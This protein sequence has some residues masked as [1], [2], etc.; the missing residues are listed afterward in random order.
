MITVINESK[1]LT[2]YISCE[3]KCQFYVRKCNCDKWWNNDKCR[4]ECEKHHICE[5]DYI[6]NPFTG[7]SENG[8]YLASIMGDLAIKY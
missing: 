4:C 8:K 2:K 1:K 6:W 7:S 3:C 5:K